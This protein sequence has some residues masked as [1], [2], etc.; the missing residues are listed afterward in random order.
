MGCAVCAELSLVAEVGPSQSI[1]APGAALQILP[2]GQAAQE[3]SSSRG[4]LPRHYEARILLRPSA[5]QRRRGARVVRCNIGGC[6]LERIPTLLQARIRHQNEHHGL[7]M[8]PS[9]AFTSFSRAFG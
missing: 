6:Y 7:H 4:S 1:T 2:V 5:F 9:I 8:I 3:L